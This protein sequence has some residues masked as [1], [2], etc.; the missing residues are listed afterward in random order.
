M[1]YTDVFKRYEY[2]YMLTRDQKEKLMETLEGHMKLDEYGRTTI[3]NI[4]YDTSDYSIIRRS[5]EKPVYK[6]KLRVRA[7]SKINEY[8]KVYVELKKKYNGIVYKRRIAVKEYLAQLW[9]TGKAQ[10]PYICQI[11]DEIEYFRRIHKGLKPSCFLSYERESF[12]STDGN[13]VR[14]TLDENILG[15]TCDL[16]LTKGILGERIIPSDY[17]LMELKVSEPIPLYLVDFLSQN[18]IQ[19]SSFSKYGTYY[20]E[21]IRHKA[22]V[23]NITGGILYA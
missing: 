9:L 2:K 3:R 17:T 6:E 18:N 16:S 13:N 21:Y 11:A 7:Y 15:R 20:Q 23:S 5:L 19:K 1:S 4:Y 10:E 8:D 22:D 14:L 12:F